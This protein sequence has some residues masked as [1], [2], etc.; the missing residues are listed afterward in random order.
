[1]AKDETFGVHRVFAA[2]CERDFAGSMT[3][4]AQWIGLNKSTIHGW[5]N[6]SVLPEIGRLAKLASQLQ[7]PVRDL[8]VGRTDSLTLDASES[9]FGLVSRERSAPRADEKRQALRDIFASEPEA[10]VRE[11]ARRLDMSHRDVYYHLFNETVQ[12]SEG[13]RHAQPPT[14]AKP[15]SAMH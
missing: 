15:E 14:A 7:M 2:V 8:V 3:R 6:G 1:M 4:L 12:H 9:T 13:R 5:L 11:A 10:S